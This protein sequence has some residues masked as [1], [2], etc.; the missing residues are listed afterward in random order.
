MTGLACKIKEADMLVEFSIIPVGAGES[1]G[2][3]IAAVLKLIDASGLPY[4]ANPMGTVIE[5]S[6]DD[7]MGLIKKCHEE[8]MKKAPRLVSS[9]T[10]DL[11]PS[12]PM[13]RIT[14]KI[15]AVEKRIGKKLKT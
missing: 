6:W 12:K 7:C 13:D 2:D 10:I 14:E 4:R 3:A 11:R 8:V 15:K 5:G 9:I 1:V